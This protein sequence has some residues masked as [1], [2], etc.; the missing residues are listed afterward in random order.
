MSPV[1]DDIIATFHFVSNKTHS[2]CSM[3][4]AEPPREH[5][6]ATNTSILTT[7]TPPRHTQPQAHTSPKLKLKLRLKLNESQRLDPP[8]PKLFSHIPMLSSRKIR[9]LNFNMSKEDD[10]DSDV[11]LI[12]KRLGMRDRRVLR[13]R[14]CVDTRIKAKKYTY[15]DESSYEED[16]VSDTQNG[17]KSDMSNAQQLSLMLPLMKRNQRILDPE[18]PKHKKLI[19]RATKVGSEYYN[20]DTED[21]PGDVRDTT[22]PHLFRNVN[23]GTYAT[24]ETNDAEF[25]TRPELYVQYRVTIKN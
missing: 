1:T 3:F 4:N 7:S 6:H 18:N 8:S 12:P 23:W 25:P 19:A 14:R 21:Q 15:H 16:S 5:Y 2:L 20:S 9:S 10:T 22:K 13:T 11:E 17:Q 24:D